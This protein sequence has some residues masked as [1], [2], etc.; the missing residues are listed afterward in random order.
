MTVPLLDPTKLRRQRQIMGLLLGLVLL[1]ALIAGAALWLAVRQAQQLAQPN[2]HN[3]LWQTYSLRA[4]LDRTLDAARHTESGEGQADDLAIRLEVLASLIAPLRRQSLF[5]HLAEPRP[6]VQATLQRLIELSDRWS[7]QAPWGDPVAARRLAA[8]IVQQV[9]P[10]LEPTHQI[11]V[12]S[13]IALTN[14][15]DV[16]RKRL[17]R[18]FY[19]LFWALLG[20]GAGGALLVLRLVTDFKRAQQLAGHLIELNATLEKRVGERTRQLSE[21]KALLH[22]ILEASPSDVVLLSACGASI[23]YVSPRLLKRLGC[24]AQDD[25]NL[26]RLFASTSEYSRLQNALEA[27]GQV[28][29]WEAQL[30]GETP[31]WAVICARHLEI[32]GEPATL[33]WCYDI[34]RRKA[35]EQELRLLASTDTLTGLHNRHSFLHQA[36]L[37]L[38]A[39]ER[40]RH[41]CVA[42]MLDIDHFKN[43]ND[44]H[45]HLTGD[46]ALQRVAETLRQGLR[47]VDL[48][49]RLGGEEF[50][51]LLPEVS[52]DQALD[53]AE[54]LRAGVEALRV[55]NPDGE[56][57]RMTVSIGVALRRDGKPAGARR[58]RALPGQE[59]R[60]QPHRVRARLT[61][62]SAEHRDHLPADRQQLAV[63]APHPRRHVAVAV[64]RLLDLRQVTAPVAAALLRQRLEELGGPGQR[65]GHRRGA[66]VR[67]QRRRPGV[68]QRQQVGNLH[69]LSLGF[70]AET[71]PAAHLARLVRRERQAAHCPAHGDVASELRGHVTDIGQLLALFGALH[72]G[73]RQRFHRHRRRAGDAETGLDQRHHLLALTD[74]DLYLAHRLALA[75]QPGAEARRLLGGQRSDEA[76][77][78]GAQRTPR[79]DHRKHGLVGQRHHQATEGGAALAPTGRYYHRGR[80]AADRLD[81]FGKIHVCLARGFEGPS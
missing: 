73:R 65:A 28:D 74:L 10:L 17:H 29:G 25:F 13:N 50:A 44:S 9:P 33:I 37:M 63:G 52:L 48:L 51:A 2:L 6:E 77:A 36:E 11:V 40:F 62:A 79:L 30:C 19:A 45:G 42:L 53:V 3:E 8:E 15:L 34:S 18:A 69:G 21:G 56:P 14:Q 70:V 49:G 54:R 32:D 68:E 46:R 57:L 31:C 26:P 71:H 64:A 66:Q 75:Q 24:Q 16:D 4:E 20:I 80:V 41:P 60:A 72:P 58:Q 5:R 1:M 67:Q 39:A 22:F 47:E 43:I 55:S 35:M 23:H 12:A 38:K 61:C 7:N 76:N 59:R 81:Q 27:R 78:D